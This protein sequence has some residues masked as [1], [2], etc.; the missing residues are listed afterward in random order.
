MPTRS[1]K[2]QILRN[3]AA[4]LQQRILDNDR[5]HLSFDVQEMAALD[6]AI[7]VLEALVPCRVL[8]KV[9]RGQPSPYSQDR[10]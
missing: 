3:R 4:Y 1:Q 10:A 8:P 7:S 2:L 6:W 5:K 9:D